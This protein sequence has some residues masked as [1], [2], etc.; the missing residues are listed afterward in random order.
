M[1]PATLQLVR[2]G[3]TAPTGTLIRLPERTAALDEA[4]DRATEAALTPDVIADLRETVDKILRRLAHNP[5]TP[6]RALFYDLGRHMYVAGRMD[7]GAD[8]AKAREQADILAAAALKQID[9]LAARRGAKDG[10]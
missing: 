2:D 6:L 10:A 9:E 7:Q 3:D 4:R 1:A 8:D 5:D